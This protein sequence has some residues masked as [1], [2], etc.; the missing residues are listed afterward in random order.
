M[1]KVTEEEVVVDIKEEVK[2]DINRSDYNFV[3][4]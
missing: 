3:I 1:S 4:K 2:F